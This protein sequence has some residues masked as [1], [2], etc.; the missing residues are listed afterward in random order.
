MLMTGWTRRAS[1]ESQIVEARAAVGTS[2]ILERLDDPSLSSPK[3]R[4]APVAGHDSMFKMKITITKGQACEL[5]KR[6]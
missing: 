1:P 4:G 2:T 6:W 3:P 5:F